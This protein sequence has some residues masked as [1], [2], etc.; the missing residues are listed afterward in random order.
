MHDTG[1]L[2]IGLGVLGGFWGAFVA[3]AVAGDRLRR[4][5]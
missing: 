4:S 3:T 2:F 1:A 5:S